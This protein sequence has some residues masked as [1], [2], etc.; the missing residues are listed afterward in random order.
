[1]RLLRRFEGHG[2]RGRLKP[3]R[4]AASK[5]LAIMLVLV[6][7]FDAKKWC[8]SIDEAQQSPRETRRSAK[9]FA[10]CR[11]SACQVFGCPALF[12]LYSP[13]RVLSW[14][15]RGASMSTHHGLSES[16]RLSRSDWRLLCF[17]L[18]FAANVPSPAHRE[19]HYA[20]SEWKAELS[21]Q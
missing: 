21:W 5:P 12:F 4:R 11:L 9:R 10:P 3:G 7:L 2:L 15:P 1:M 16:F 18:S 17:V 13:L 20:P 6:L 8:S 14:I 19:S